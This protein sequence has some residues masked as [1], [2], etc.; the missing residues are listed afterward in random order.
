MSFRSQRKKVAILISGNGSN[1]KALIEDMED[2]NHPGE[3]SLVVSDEPSAK[4]LIIA[5]SCHI[6]TKVVNGKYYQT[7]KELFEKKIKTSIVE[8]KSDVICLAGFM[9]ILSPKFVSFF[10]NKI[11]NIHPSILPLFKGLNTHEKAIASG[12][13]LHGATVHRVTNE[14][15]SGPILGQTIIPILAGDTKETLAARLLPEENKLYPLTL[16]R[17]LSNKFDPVLIS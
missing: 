4:G 9:K 6:K 13:A 8:S 2:P 16:R 7:E 5:N 3:V 14:L 12:M 15:D 11:I 10:E 17:F 1:M